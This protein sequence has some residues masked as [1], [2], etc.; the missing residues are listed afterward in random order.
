VKHQRADGGPQLEPIIMTS[1]QKTA[2]KTEAQRARRAA[3]KAGV[4]V[5]G[6]VRKTAPVKKAKSAKAA[7]APAKPTQFET[8]MERIKAELAKPIEHK[9]SPKAKPAKVARRTG[10]GGKGG[11]LKALVQREGGAS[12]T[13]LIKTLGWQAHTIRAALSRLR[14]DGMDITRSDGGMDGSVYSAPPAPRAPK[15]AEAEGATA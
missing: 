1:K 10:D 9:A 7:A 3:K 14:K 13:H 12:I 6:T 8:R 2:A 5:P 11:Q 4:F 15:K